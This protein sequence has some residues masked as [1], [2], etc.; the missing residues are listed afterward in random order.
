MRI[1][2]A[3][4]HLYALNQRHKVVRLEVE[5]GS[6]ATASIR[7]QVP[8]KAEVSE[9]QDE[10]GK[11]RDQRLQRGLSGPGLGRVVPKD[12]SLRPSSYTMGSYG[13]DVSLGFIQGMARVGQVE[14]FKIEVLTRAPKTIAKKLKGSNIS[15]IPT[16]VPSSTWTEDYSERT[17]TGATLVPVKINSDLVDEAVFPQRVRRF[18]GADQVPPKRFQNKLPRQMRW[19]FPRAHFSVHGAVSSSNLQRMPISRAVSLNQMVRETASHIEGGNMLCGTLPNG[20]GYALIGQDSVAVTRAK[21][22][23]DL[24]KRVGQ[25]E[26]LD[27]IAKD[28][29]LERE[30]VHAIEQ[31][32]EFH[33][34]M[35]ILCA[36]PGQV[37][38][39][40]AREAY[41]IQS[42]WMREAYQKA[43]PRPLPADASPAKRKRHRELTRTWR[44]RGVRLK[45]QL[46]AMRGEAQKRAR[47]EARTLADLMK[48]GLSIHRMP[49]VFVD[50]RDPR[51]DIANFVNG[52]G[53]TNLKGERFYIG[54]GSRTPME[55]LAADY[56]MRKIPTGFSKIYFLDSRL[57]QPTLDMSGGIK[58]RTKPFGAVVESRPVPRRFFRIQ[59]S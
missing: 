49:A 28:L 37:I 5:P 59:Q 44:Q 25:G 34:D 26:A 23:Q 7:K 14:D 38:V 10:L 35:R 41:R 55:E 57:T 4:L 33:V 48:T 36:A 46:Q 3:P 20:Q 30:N 21:L 45:K 11:A 40:D 18:Y 54:L 50:P 17:V 19:R 29:G 42:G 53:G 43:K 24:G 52:R 32:G 51:R 47:F 16:K 31:P 58:C 22:S 12:A 15:I 56:L 1:Q 27:W 8:T 6:Q 39:N 9:H 13:D 2:A